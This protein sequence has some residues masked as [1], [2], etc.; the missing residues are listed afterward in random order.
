MD[1]WELRIF[2]PYLTAFGYAELLRTAKEEG[3]LNWLTPDWF[4]ENEV[5]CSKEKLE[6]LIKQVKAK[7]K[8]V[9]Y[10]TY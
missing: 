2:Q 4:F 5:R 7:K 8:E 6:E 1:L 9:S 10:A 3:N